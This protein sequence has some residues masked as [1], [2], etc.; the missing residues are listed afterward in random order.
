[1]G[2][3]VGGSGLKL[4]LN[5]S[6]P[7]IAEKLFP[8]PLSKFLQKHF[9]NLGD[10]RSFFVHPGG[11]KV[12]ETLENSLGL[13]EKALKHSWES[14]SKNGNMSSVSILDVFKRAIDAKPGR[15]AGTLALSVAMGPGFSAEIGLFKWR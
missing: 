5:K 2:W 9:L 11:P 4:I 3:K 13:P 7:K 14:L 10:I 12:L 1:M 6:I 8:V 15:F